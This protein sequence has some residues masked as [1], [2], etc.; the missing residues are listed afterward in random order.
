[1]NTLRYDV[2][3]INTKRALAES[4]KN[5]VN[6]NYPIR[7]I[8]VKLITD[9]C[10]V[11]RNTFY[12]HFESI[13][14]L[15]LWILHDEMYSRMNS[16]D[17]SD[18]R[19]FR[20]FIVSYLA[21][22]Q[23]FLRETYQYLGYVDFHRNYVKELI[24]LVDKHIRHEA[25]LS[26]L[27]LNESFVSFLSYFFADQ[28]GSLYVMQFHNPG[29]YSEQTVRKSLEMI[30]DISIPYMLKEQDTIGRDL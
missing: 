1:M 19:A 10:S 23:K 27:E 30:F 22:N 25:Q 2:N 20:D 11:S 26:N 13:N 17:E 5:L 16:F 7:K 6:K 9:N 4:V 29:S 24:P 18:S 8:T 14:D 3:S 12:Y 21:E 15:I 28:V